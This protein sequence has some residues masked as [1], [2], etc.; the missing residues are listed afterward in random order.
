MPTSEG[1]PYS[2]S[3]FVTTT[4]YKVVFLKL[5]VMYSFVSTCHVHDAVYEGVLIH[6]M[7]L[8]FLYI[9]FN[10]SRYIDSNT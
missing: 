4:I 10:I 7:I 6:T 5:N 8:N 3:N 1:L 2:R 9:F